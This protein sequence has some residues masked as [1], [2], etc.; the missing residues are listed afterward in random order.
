MNTFLT[1]ALLTTMII[2]MHATTPDMLLGQR[3]LMRHRRGLLFIHPTLSTTT[4]NSL[5]VERVLQS[6]TPMLEHSTIHGS[7]SLSMPNG[8]PMSLNDAA[9]E[10]LVE[11]KSTTAPMVADCNDWRP[12]P[13]S[14]TTRTIHS[15]QES[16]SSPAVQS[17]TT[18]TK[19]APATV[20]VGAVLA[21]VA[22]MAVVFAM[23]RHRR[24]TQVH[25]TF[26]M[27]DD[28]NNNKDD[29]LP[30]PSYQVET[31]DLDSSSHMEDID[32]DA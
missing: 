27:N 5:F 28:S 9:P 16:V 4:T 26:M 24:R 6:D 8:V 12:E 1:L 31:Q 29:A 23:R 21:V 10:A 11:T 25:D 17:T 14:T 2:P 13:V 15:L 32:I 7:F 20:I 19:M 22:A 18:T 3:A 30:V